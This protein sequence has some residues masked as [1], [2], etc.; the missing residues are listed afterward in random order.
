LGWTSSNITLT[1]SADYLTLAASGSDPQFISPPIALAGSTFR[2]I[3]IDYERVNSGT[4]DGK[5]FY[6]I[7]GGHS[8]SASFYNDIPDLAVGERRTVRI[9]MH[10]LAVG[11][12][13]WATNTIT[14][15]RL[16]F[17]SGSGTNFRVYSV[18]L[19]YI[20][21]TGTF[22]VWVAEGGVGG[23]ANARLGAVG[24]D[25]TFNTNALV[26]KGGG[27]GGQFSEN[28]SFRRDNGLAGGCGGG[29]SNPTSGTGTGGAGEAGQGL[30]GGSQA[31]AGSEWKGSGGGGA[32]EAGGQGSSGT[33]GDG[34][35]G[36]DGKLSSITGFATYYGG[37]GGGGGRNANN[38]G[39]GNG[40]GGG[41]RGTSGADLANPPGEDGIDYFGGGGGGTRGTTA[42]GSVT[43]G[44]K[45]GKGI[46]ILRYRN[47]K[48]LGTTVATGGTVTEAQGYRIHTFEYGET[49]DFVITKQ[50]LG[51]IE[52]LIVA[53]GGGGGNGNGGGGGGGG[54]LEGRAS[55]APGTYDVTIGAGGAAS[56]VTPGSGRGGQGGS[57]SAFGKTVPGGGG[58]G[59]GNVDTNT[60]YGVGGSGSS[61]GGGAAF[62]GSHAGGA[63]T[64]PYGFAGS[65][66]IDVSPYRDGGGGGAGEPGG[67]PGSTTGGKGGNG[68][69]SWITGAAVYYGGGGGGAVGGVGTGGAGGLG[70]GGNGNSNGGAGSQDGTDGLGG[71][72]GGWARGGTPHGP[73]KRGGHGVVIIR[74]PIAPNVPEFEPFGVDYLTTVSDATNTTVYTFNGVT[75]GTPEPTRVIHLA[76]SCWSA[77]NGLLNSVT[78]G[79]ITATIIRQ[80]P[81]GNW[82]KA[83]HVY[84]HVPLGTSG[85]VVLNFAAT[86]DSVAVSAYRVVGWSRIPVD[87]GQTETN[88]TSASMTLYRRKGGIF[89]GAAMANNANQMDW[90]TASW[91]DADVVPQTRH[92]AAHA[93]LG[94]P[95][96]LTV[97]VTGVGTTN[98]VIA[99][100]QWA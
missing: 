33:T 69:I 9:D 41:G 84:A 93:F 11:G 63:G 43:G 77:A 4:F 91:E 45:G 30:A 98:R 27:G 74:Y 78:I 60:T 55:A 73:G 46:V 76:I 79:G 94:N 59:G 67:T 88:S 82:A 68:K 14:S 50:G 89:I 87:E 7:S 58:G 17:A 10:A 20:L 61:G 23:L 29:A 15:L 39:G 92:S 49:D 65:A 64:S 37:G 13:D 57:S 31:S 25:S 47:G 28:A 72:A 97:G 21:G 85:Q 19:P 99:A 36:G 48:T 24:Q 52:Y 35:K 81:S 3:D 75:F 40:I 100:V 18:S 51:P 32:A 71:G 34:G 12:T 62:W 44:G 54:V 56:A 22:P 2:Y 86:Q 16:D 90:T 95:G 80:S 96:A 6:A 53:G 66:A 38:T 26:A 70:G 42:N 83:I 5:L 1:P 8:Y